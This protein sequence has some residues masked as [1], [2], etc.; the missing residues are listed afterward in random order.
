ML[1]ITLPDGSKRQFPQAVTVQ[2]IAESISP[3][4][5]KQMVAGCV[6]GQLVDTSYLVEKD[7]A[8]E[9]VTA[10]H[11]KGLEVLRHSAAHLLAHA[12]KELFPRHK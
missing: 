5:A 11:P 12:V 4:L 10:D 7:A 9:I 2:A 6:N 3:E 1:V 8:I